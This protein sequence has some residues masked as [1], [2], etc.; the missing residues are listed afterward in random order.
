MG[1]VLIPTIDELDIPALEKHLEQVRN[2]RI[3]TAIQYQ[4]TRNLKLSSEANKLE[5][6]LKKQVDLLGKDLLKLDAQLEKCKERLAKV[7]MLKNELGFVV[8]TMT[9]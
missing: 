5:G 6:Q 8:S 2:K 4:Q 9:E 1:L 3:I 7:N